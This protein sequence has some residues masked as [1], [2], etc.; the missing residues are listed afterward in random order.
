[1]SVA[2]VWTTVHQGTAPPLDAF[3]H[4]LIERAL[5]RAPEDLVIEAIRHASRTNQPLAEAL[6]NRGGMRANTQPPRARTDPTG[7]WLIEPTA[8]QA[9][10]AA[11]RMG[12]AQANWRASRTQPLG[13]GVHAVEFDDEENGMRLL[14]LATG[15]AGDLEPRDVKKILAWVKAYAKP[16]DPND[17]RQQWKAALA[18]VTGSW[19]RA[20]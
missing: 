9:A 15:E 2:S 3:T 13:D 10:E 14:N 7:Q 12:R 18:T 16:Y 5:L 4:S 8:D 1:M 6:R 19:K 11:A 20:L 17:P